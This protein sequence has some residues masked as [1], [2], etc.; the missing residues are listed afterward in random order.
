MKCVICKLGEP[1]PGQTTMTITRGSMTLVIKDIPA[2][3]CHD[4]GEA[5]L[6]EN[7]FAR[8]R[9]LADD[10]ERAGVQVDVRAYRAPNS[11]VAVQGAVT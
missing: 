4:G 10:A 1:I 3:V 11:V 7:T 2:D 9:N 6:E 5:Y 8:L